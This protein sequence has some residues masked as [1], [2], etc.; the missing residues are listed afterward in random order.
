[1]KILLRGNM[2]EAGE[3]PRDQ[4]DGGQGTSMHFRR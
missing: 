1:M 2:L 4:G 3:D